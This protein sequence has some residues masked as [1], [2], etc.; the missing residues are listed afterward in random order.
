MAVR[1]KFFNLL[2]KSYIALALV[3]LA[4]A[5]VTARA[6]FRPD[7]YAAANR[8][9]P[10]WTVKGYRQLTR[11]PDIAIFGSSLMLAAV[12]D[13]DA[14]AF[15][16]SFDELL[17]HQSLFFE[18]QLARR[19]DTPQTT[20]SLAIGGQ[21]AS[22]AYALAT[23]L[24]SNCHKPKT[25][26]WGVAPRDLLDSTFFDPATSDTVKYLDKVAADETDRA[27]AN[28]I[29]W[30][31]RANYLADAEKTLRAISFV[32]SRRDDLQA[33]AQNELK[34]ALQ[35]SGQDLE[36]VRAPFSLLH[37]PCARVLEDNGPGEW[38]VEP[39]HLK[40]P[41]FRD[42]SAEYRMRYNP[43]RK[44]LFD[45]QT[46]Y[47]AKFLSFCRNEGIAVVLV[48]MPLMKENM[49]LMP[50]G[51]YTLYRQSIERLAREYGAQLVDF[52]QQGLFAR[53]DFADSVHLNGPGG[54]RLWQ[55][56]AE[57][58][59]DNSQLVAARANSTH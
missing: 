37:D 4:A 20:Q 15:D 24:F 25:I 55:M 46:K 38:I 7:P 56:L 30:Q 6:F 41:T 17:H 12:N 5:D 35:A 14:T 50:D 13:A 32:Y 22:D 53:A 21:M 27:S 47:L 52:N 40:D 1:A 57:R 28:V 54:M 49:D 59:K 34:H 19:F 29:D 45:T 33:V 9:W 36:L 2:A 8:T 31:G 26:V 10:Y 42:V 58:M 3:G 23:S 11:T 18:A 39:Y 16:T 51:S 48:N 44:E 43:F